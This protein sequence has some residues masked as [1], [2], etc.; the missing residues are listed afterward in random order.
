GYGRQSAAHGFGREIH[1]ATPGRSGYLLQ[2]EHACGLD[3]SCERLLDA[4]LDLLVRFLMLLPSVQ[5]R[6]GPLESLEEDARIQLIG[7]YRKGSGIELLFV[8]PIDAEIL[9]QTPVLPLDQGLQLEQK[10]GLADAAL[11]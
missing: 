8:L 5:L 6:G 3:R 9:E 4:R 11:S 1:P 2:G 10:S 7:W